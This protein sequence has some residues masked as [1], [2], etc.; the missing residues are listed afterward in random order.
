MTRTSS[1]VILGGGPGG[2]E[3][4]LVAAHLGASVTVVDRDGIGGAAVLTDCVPSKTLIATADYLGDMGTASEL[5]VHL[6]DHEGDV[7]TRTVAELGAINERVLNLA[8]AQSADIQTRLTEVG[9]R[10]VAG[11]GRMES[12]SRVVVET[13]AGSETLDAD[14]VL[15]STGATPRVLDSATPDGERILTWQQIYAL[16]EIP[17]KLI[18]VGSGVTGAELAQ[19]Y[20]GLGT[21]VTLVSSRDLVLPQEDQDAAAV[22]EDVFRRRGMTILNRSRMAGAQRRGDGVVVTLE[23]GREV[24]GS[25]VLIAVG[26]VP[27]TSGLGLEDVGVDVSESGHVVVDR[28][29]RTSVRGVYAA[30]DCTGVFALASVAA[31]QGR[32]AMAHALGDAVAP[33]RMSAVSANVF[34]DPEIAT[35][36]VSAAD[37]E[38]NTDIEA[39]MM[40]LSRNP[41]AKMLDIREGFVKLF[42]YRGTGIVVGGVIVA[43]RASELIFPVTLAVQNRLSVDQVASTFTVYPSLSGTV[44]EAARRLHPLRPE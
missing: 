1:V 37:A 24:E 3:A 10:V 43:P 5:G 13:D 19:A 34:T 8:A 28:V 26:A 9:V 12:P 25:H 23:D 41:R 17:E 15:V 20:L 4:A 35:V 39:V 31:M 7:A 2:Y 42:A 16:P 21:D 38:D 33:L 27:Q 32:T 36:G 40:P 29:S 18:V 6:E 44:A 30:G 11:A 14:V 22:I